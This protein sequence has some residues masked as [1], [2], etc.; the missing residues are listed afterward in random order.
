M[1]MLKSHKQ[2]I[3]IGIVYYALY[4][5]QWMLWTMSI[6]W[7]FFSDF[8]QLVIFIH[9][10]RIFRSLQMYMNKYIFI[11]WYSAQRNVRYTPCVNLTRLMVFWTDCEMVYKVFKINWVL[12]WLFKC[13][14]YIIDFIIL[15]T[16]SIPSL[17]LLITLPD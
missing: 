5:K 2:P 4:F 12:F 8:T 11:D 10:K 9:V 14:V 3:S 6:V 13:A 16:S 17:E 1:L 7:S 15:P